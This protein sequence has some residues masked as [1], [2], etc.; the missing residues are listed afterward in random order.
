M[1]QTRVP[2]APQERQSI[3]G[4]G[5]PGLEQFVRSAGWDSYRARQIWRWV[6]RGRVTR[7]AQMSD[8][9]RDVRQRLDDELLVLET[10]L[11]QVR[12]DPDQTRKLLLRLCDGHHVECVLLPDG[13]R[14]TACLSTQVGCA[15]RCTFCASGIEGLHRD[16]AC[17]EIV[18]QVLWLQTQLSAEERLTHIV[19][20]GMGEPLANLDGLL[21]ALDMICSPEGLRLSARRV[22]VSTV[23]LPGRIDKLAGVGRP[24]HLAVSLHAPDDALRRRLVPAGRRMGLEALVNESLAYQ[25]ATGR[26]TTFEYLLLGGV[27]DQP[28]HARTLAHLLHGTGAHVNLIPYNP[29]I[30]KDLRQSTPEAARRFAAVLRQAGVSVKTRKRRGSGIEAACGQL[31]ICH[32]DRPSTAQ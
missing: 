23:G 4:L 15:M 1:S 3:V 9:P 8:I 6:W 31:R 25:E 32:Q 26:Q 30:K 24:Y 2:R 22:T 13:R 19:V 11:A 10:D 7:F 17:H 28:Q 18:E 29:I 20:M 5:L 14:R 27:N 16:L 21:P 12:V